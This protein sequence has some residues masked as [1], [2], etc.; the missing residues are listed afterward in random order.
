VRANGGLFAVGN[1]AGEAHPV[2]AE[3]ISMAM[4]AAWLLAE[5]LIVHG[6]S[7]QDWQAVGED[8][9]QAWRRAFAPRLR[10]AAAFAHWAMRP[11]AV[12]AAL[13]LVRTFPAILGWG[14]RLSGKTT[15]VVV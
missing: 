10:A 12:A 1:A 11:A 5:R 9:A 8:Y 15:R 7:S 14:A 2:I 4:Q 6:P 13:P 3:G